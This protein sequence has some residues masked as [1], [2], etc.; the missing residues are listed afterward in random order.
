MQCWW[1]KLG[2]SPQSKH[3]SVGTTSKTSTMAS[4]VSVERVAVTGN[5]QLNALWLLVVM[6][7]VKNTNKT[8]KCPHKSLQVHFN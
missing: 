8:L 3:P 5:S 7:A 2:Q 4:A 6:A 1:L